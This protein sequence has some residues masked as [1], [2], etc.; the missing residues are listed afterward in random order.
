[1]TAL[2][3]QIS[4][5]S[6]LYSHK[7]HKRHNWK[8]RVIWEDVVDSYRWQSDL[9]RDLRCLHVSGVLSQAVLLCSAGVWGWWV[10]GELF[11]EAFWRWR[12]QVGHYI[13]QASRGWWW[14]KSIIW[15]GGWVGW[16]RRGDNKLALWD[17]WRW[18]G[19]LNGGRNWNISTW[20]VRWELTSLQSLLR[21]WWV[22][23]CTS[24]RAWNMWTNRS[25]RRLFC[26]TS[27]GGSGW[28]SH[29][30]LHSCQCGLLVEKFLNVGPCRALGLSDGA[31]FLQGP[32]GVVE[33]LP[34]GFQVT[35]TLMP[36]RVGN[37][38]KQ[39][40]GAER[41][42]DALRFW[43]GALRWART[44]AAGTIV[45]HLSFWCRGA[46]IDVR[47]LWVQGASTGNHWFPVH[48]R[49]TGNKLFKTVI[50]EEINS[51]SH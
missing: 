3:L 12:G 47:V 44:H 39:L 18:S 13:L 4:K 51:L 22:V 7:K 38:G 48:Y 46:S 33:L 31:A 19:Q 10:W 1:M 2:T 41:P 42:R 24:H 21:L 6:D 50:W 35:I 11:Q 20:D 16:R 29:S 8:S 15:F 45:V 32:R 30:G 23:L 40:G 34:Q 49:Q 26:F 36:V 17:G 28:C 5:I 27:V 37:E 14:K 25:L 9:T 43:L